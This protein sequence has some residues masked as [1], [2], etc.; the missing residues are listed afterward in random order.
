LSV[1]YFSS[2]LDKTIDMRLVQVTTRAFD[3]LSQMR[4]VT[5]GEA[6]TKMK[7]FDRAKMVLNAP[8]IKSLHVGPQ[9]DSG[10]SIQA[11]QQPSTSFD[12]SLGRG[13]DS[14]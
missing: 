2:V 5:I 1:Y 13:R 3:T 9:Q 10:A 6:E 8:I 7:N 14:C 4:G 11:L 12:S